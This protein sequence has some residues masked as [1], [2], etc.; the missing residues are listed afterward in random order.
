MKKNLYLFR[1]ALATKS[2][3]GYGK[4]I[5]SATLLDDGIPAFKKLT[6]FLK[7]IRESLNISSKILRCR[8]SAKIISQ[9][10][11]KK[12]IY[13]PR[14]NE[15]YHEEFEDFT[16]RV[17]DFLQ[18]LEKNDHQNIII[19]TH[20]IVIA[21]I[22]NLILKGKFTKSNRYDYPPTGE[23]VIIK[24]NKIQNIDFNK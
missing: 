9:I 10:T 24:N 19:C 11:H 7:D 14:I 2:K 13:D 23:L 1:H 4:K 5:L 15:F 3:R 20:G 16:K 17:T 18:D 12:F 8:Q 21:A 22:K 6:L